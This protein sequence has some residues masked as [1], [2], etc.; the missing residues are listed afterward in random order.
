FENFF[1][2]D[3]CCGGTG[4]GWGAWQIAARYSYLDAT[5][6]NI[7]GGI[8]HDA[9]LGLVWYFNENA[10]LQFNWEHGW[11]TDS[12]DLTAAMLPEAE[13]DVIGMRCLIQF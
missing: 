13:Y 8:G 6:G 9:T 1:L 4:G 10:K 12:A 3:R 11:I 7:M 2:I 5:D